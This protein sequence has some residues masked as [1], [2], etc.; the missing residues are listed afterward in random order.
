VRNLLEFDGLTPEIVV[1]LAE[2]DV[3]SL[4]DFADLA[5]DELTEMLGDDMMK[6]RD[7]EKLIMK[8]RERWFAE[9]D[10]QIAESESTN[11]EETQAEEK[12][13][14]AEEAPAPVASNA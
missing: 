6:E 4:D 10:A 7:A 8:A 3:K 9:E 1:K 14:D 5:T 13:A 12:T 2:N 11:P